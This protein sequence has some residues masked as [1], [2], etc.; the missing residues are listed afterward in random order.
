MKTRNKLLVILGPTSSG[1]TRLAVA[2]AKKFDGEIVS[3][4]SR[5]VYRDMD[6]GTGKDLKE[7]GTIPYHLIDVASPRVRFSV[8]QYQRLAY[9]TIRDILRRGKLPILAGGTGLYIQSIV[10]GTVFPKA[11]PDPKLRQKLAKLSLPAL[12][13]KLTTLD[14]ATFARIDKRNRR[15][16]ERAVEICILTRK[17][18]SEQRLKNPP[19]YD[20]LQIGIALPKETLHKKIDARLR[21]RLGKT[22]HPP[23]SHKG[24]GLKRGGGLIEEVQKL[25][26]QGLSWKR[27]DEFGLEYR[28]VSR[29]LRGKLSLEQM[30]G[31]LSRAIKNFSKRQMSWFKR[32]PRIHWVSSAQETR[33]LVIK[34]LHPKKLL[35]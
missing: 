5:Q 6:I 28:F 24:R 17:P 23:L 3:A 30:N 29:Y 25:H 21:E 26:R 9:K 31:K 13:R 1:K 14:P 15:R 35:Q 18:L 34:F 32:D 19:P 22:P 10:D 16:V 4:D 20:I 11:K 2:L 12:L 8:A 7:Y 33:T 27:L